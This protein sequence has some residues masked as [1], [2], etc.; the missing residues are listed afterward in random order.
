[1]LLDKIGRGGKLNLD[2]SRNNLP[3]YLNDPGKI[4][5]AM[6]ILAAQRRALNRL[7][8]GHRFIPKT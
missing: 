1:M 6:G 3:A 7:N 8:L 5:R 2:P 4:V